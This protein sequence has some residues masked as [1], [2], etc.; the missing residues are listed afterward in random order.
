MPPVHRLF[1]LASRPA[2]RSG[3]AGFEKSMK[4]KRFGT[5][6]DEEFEHLE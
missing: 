6:G 5:H 1:G 4:I 2:M 3:H